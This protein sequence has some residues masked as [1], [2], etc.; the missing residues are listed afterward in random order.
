MQL[1]RSTVRQ[2]LDEMERDGIIHRVERKGTFV[3]ERQSPELASRTAALAI[4]VLEVSSGYYLS[5][6]SGFEE[7]CART[8][9][10]A[11]VCNS[12]NSIDRQGNHL[13]SLLAHR[14]SGVVLNAC[15]M[16]ATP[17]HHVQLLQD[18]GIPVVLLH[19][20][21]PKISAPVLALPA[22]EVSRKAARMLIDAGHRHVAC[23][24]YLSCDIS[25]RYKA[26]F[27]QA[28]AEAGIDLP[29]SHVDYSHS[30]S[31]IVTSE[32]DEHLNEV[33]PR[34]LSLPNRPTAI[35]A[36]FDPIAEHI[37]LAAQRLGI[38]IPEELSI[39]SFGGANREGAI[40]KRLSALTVDEVSA[41]KKAVELLEEMRSGRRPIDD[42]EVFSLLLSTYKGETL[43][44][45]PCAATNMGA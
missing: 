44:P 25:E 22:E 36:V 7:A 3:S 11:L 17:P 26:G 2:T 38:R 34:M 15:S 10:P 24:Q 12:A 18:A 43:K 33:L 14:V 45:P 29:D 8:G 1:S 28:L 21:V 30:R 37:Y 13:L 23:F 39:I 31:A 16:E 32:Y 27:R 4:V 35:Y 42:G 20:A 19:R 9:L 41:G 5:L 40:L 6:L